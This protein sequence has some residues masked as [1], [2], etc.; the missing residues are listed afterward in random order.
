ME[1]QKARF[2]ASVHN[3]TEMCFEKCVRKCRSFPFSLALFFV[4]VAT[5]LLL[6]VLIVLM[7][8]KPG[9]RL[10]KSEEACLAF[11]VDR[12]L[13]MSTLFV[14]RLQQSQGRV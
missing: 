7:P 1:Q 6:C 8:A 9:N 14:G 3:F 5:N 13:D 2:Q 4:G 12:F 10:D 11:C